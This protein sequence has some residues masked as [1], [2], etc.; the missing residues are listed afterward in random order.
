MPRHILACAALLALPALLGACS[1]QKVYDTT[2]SLRESSCNTLT[3]RERDDCL[4]QARDLYR[5]HTTLA[6]PDA[7]G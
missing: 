1:A 3:G 2:T 7:R 4:A 6:N 5:P